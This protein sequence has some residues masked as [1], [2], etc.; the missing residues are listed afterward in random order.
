MTLAINDNTTAAAAV[1]TSSSTTTTTSRILNIQSP[2]N[3]EN[4][5]LIWKSFIVVAIDG[6]SN[7]NIL[8]SFEAF[9][10]LC[11]SLFVRS[12]IY[13]RHRIISHKT[14]LTMGETDGV[15]TTFH[16]HFEWVGVCRVGRTRPVGRFCQT[17]FEC[18]QSSDDWVVWFHSHSVRK[19]RHKVL[20]TIVS[21]ALTIW[22]CNTIP[23]IYHFVDWSSYVTMHSHS[24][25]PQINASLCARVCR[26]YVMLLCCVL[27]YMNRMVGCKPN[28]LEVYVC[29]CV[30]CQSERQWAFGKWKR[31]KK[32]GQNEWSHDADRLATI[33]LNYTY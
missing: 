7:I 3:W 10:C 17:S 26:I 6:I 2:G 23:F 19:S 25:H 31:K 29:E 9:L 14:K 13:P 22:K 18:F 8:S 20:S 12:W 4:R 27:T 21:C 30:C 24:I 32:L 5:K 15:F 28:T 1:G 16:F 33:K 11:L